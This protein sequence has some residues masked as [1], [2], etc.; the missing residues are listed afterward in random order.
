MFADNM[1][2][3]EN[4][5]AN[6]MRDISCM[7]QQAEARMSAFE[8]NMHDGYPMP[9]RTSGVDMPGETLGGMPAM[10]AAMNA[11][12][13]AANC[14]GMYANASTALSGPQGAGFQTSA[15]FANTMDDV[16][17]QIR[18]GSEVIIHDLNSAPE[19]NG[20]K[21]TCLQWHLINL[22]GMLECTPIGCLP[23]NLRSLISLV[24]SGVVVRMCRLRSLRL[25]TL[26]V[27]ATALDPK[28]GIN[29]QISRISALVFRISALTFRESELSLLAPISRISAGIFRISALTLR[30]SVL[31]LVAPRPT[32]KNPS[33]LPLE[34]VTLDGA[35]YQ[36]L[37][38]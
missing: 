17:H 13:Q 7:M 11:Q 5:F 3:L 2:G 30:V 38:A 27:I 32:T 19:L 20:T 35:W 36:N 23:L 9:P 28:H 12:T 14:R 31:S 4:M 8:T 10:I 29:V 26:K 15:H 16:R 25:A 18:E 1:G 21:G 22:V 34:G 37:N 24:R 33:G 6:Q